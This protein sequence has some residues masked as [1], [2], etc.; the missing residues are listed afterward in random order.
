M[1][2]AGGTKYGPPRVY[3]RW[4][5][6]IRRMRVAAATTAFSL[7]LTKDVWPQHVE[8][9]VELRWIEQLERRGDR[10]EERVA[11]LRRVAEADDLSWIRHAHR[12]ERDHRLGED[13]AEVTV[14]A[15][16][17]KD[18]VDRPAL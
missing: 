2:V 10:R 17:R 7:N 16:E 3:S 13:A 8:P 14:I 4:T 6:A 1:I 5:K 9:F 18:L 12:R 15:A 11:V